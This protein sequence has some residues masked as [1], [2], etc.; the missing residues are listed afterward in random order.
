MIVQFIPIPQS[1]NI[2]LNL[3]S[4]SSIS[5]LNSLQ[6]L[7]LPKLLRSHNRTVQ[8]QSYSSVWQASYSYSVY[9]TILEVMQSALMSSKKISIFSIVALK[10]S[11]WE[12]KLSVIVPYF[13]AYYCCVFKEIKIWSQNLDEMLVTYIF[14]FFF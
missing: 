2:A 5:P 9:V 10:N 4:L 13:F 3:A 12:N 1:S 7:L 11:K 14:T 8:V 6:Q